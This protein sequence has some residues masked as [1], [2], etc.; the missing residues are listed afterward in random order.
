MARVPAPEPSRGQVLIR[1]EGS[2]ICGSEVPVFEGRR[3]FEYPQESGAPGHEGWGVVEAVGDG[4]ENVAV[5]QRVAALMYHAHAEYDVA[6]EAAVVPLPPELDGQPFPGEALACALNVFK[7]SDVRR[8]QTVAVVGIGF[9]GA[10]L[11]RLAADAGAR[12]IAATRR[13]SALD[14]AAS[15]GATE[16]LVLDDPDNVVTEIEALTGGDLCDRVLEVTGKQE[17][18]DIAARLTR[19]RGR[20]VIAG[21]HQDGDRRVDMQLWN[22]RGLDVVNAHE[23]DREVYVQGLRE[24]V[25]AV[26]TGRLDP[27]PLYTHVFP[28]ERLQDA[29]LTAIERP[30]GFMK[31]LVTA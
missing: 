4:V 28:L 27:S 31:A 2:G 6:D 5:G 22:W 13:R 10:L 20:L 29:L 18:L 12:V 24:A 16:T 3:W 21:F 23:R 25:E 7:R 30:A 26:R 14:V 17:P 9:L 11:T 15:L 8:G 19:E 1:I